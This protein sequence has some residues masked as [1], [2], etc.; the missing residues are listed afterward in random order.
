MENKKN[1]F[2]K[3]QNNLCTLTMRKLNTNGNLE[4]DQKK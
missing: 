2:K 1:E 3:K 4:F